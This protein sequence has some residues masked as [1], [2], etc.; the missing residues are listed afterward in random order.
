L[1]TAVERKTKYTCIQPVR[2]KTADAVANALITMLMPFQNQILTITVDNGKEFA[3]HQ[4]VA[5]ALNTNV[6]FAHPYHAWERGLNENTNGLLRQYF[7]KKSSF[8][9]ITHDQVKFV[10]NRLNS[11]PRKLLQF[12]TPMELFKTLL[13]ALET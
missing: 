12:K 11:R 5:D 3:H 7:P 1:V 4:H 9:G 8:E 2:R 13:V 10:E 6:Y